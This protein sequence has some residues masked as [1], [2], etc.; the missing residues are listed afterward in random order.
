MYFYSFVTIPNAK[1]AFI[2]PD[3]CLQNNLVHGSMLKLDP[4]LRMHVISLRFNVK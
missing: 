1:G 4:T 2:L 3:M